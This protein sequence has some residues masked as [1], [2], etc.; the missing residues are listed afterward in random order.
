MI[1]LFEQNVRKNDRNSSKGNQL[2]W[3]N[4]GI[5]YKADFLGYEGLAE[6]VVSHLLTYS[7]LQASEYVLYDLEEIAYA[8]NIFAGC[9]SQSFLTDDWQ[10]ITLER[11]FKNAYGKSLYET[12]W[13]IRDVKERF[14]FMV[15][16]VQSI[17]GLKDFD[18]YLA[19]LLTLDALFL[20]EDRH[21]HNVAVLGNGSGAYALCPIF[22][23][24]ACL[25][26]DTKFD[27][28]M[29]ED[30]YAYFSESKAKTISKDFDEQLEIAEA[31]VGNVLQFHFSLSDVQ[32]ILASASMYNHPEIA[33]V[34]IIL[35]EQMRKYQYM[36]QK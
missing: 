3:E 27:Y 5:W 29:K 34:E 9:K 28:P 23:N 30:V 12:V 1:E 25:L 6:Y 11:L 32:E 2:K 24:G 8:R 16:T 7:S 13:K 10:I 26:S 4:D 36:F 22:D 33:R 19:K 35:Q 14:R 15:S 31:L 17:T 18:V 20:N 21:M